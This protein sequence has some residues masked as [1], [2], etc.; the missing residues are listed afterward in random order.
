MAGLIAYHFMVA[1][2]EYIAV[3]SVLPFHSCALISRIFADLCGFSLALPCLAL[4]SLSCSVYCCAW[5]PYGI[6]SLLN[7]ERSR[8]R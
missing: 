5:V 6:P 2:R 4:F 3:L 8:A 7:T 1:P